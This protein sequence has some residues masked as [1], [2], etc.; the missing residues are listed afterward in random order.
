LLQ[1]S[2]NPVDWYPWGTDALDKARAENKPIFLSIGYSACHW[3]HVME[4]ESFENDDIAAI[5]NRHFVNIKVD[6]EERPDLDDFFMTFLQLTTGAGGWPM[7]VFLTPDGKPFFGGTYFPPEDAYGRRGFPF[8]LK[9]VTQTWSVQQQQVLDSST[10]LLAELQANLAA[11]GPGGT[12]KPEILE[13]AMRQM[14]DRFDPVDGGFGG[15]PKFPPSYSL[16]LLMK[17]YSRSRNPHLLRAIFHTLDRMAFGGIYDHL[18]GGFHRY[19]VDAQWLTPH[20]EKMLY[21]NAL[22]AAVYLEAYQLTGKSLYRT[23]ATETLDYVLR[24]MRDPA[25]GF[26]SSEDADSE[27][28]EGK[29]YVW[30]PEEVIAALGSHN[31]KLFCD[32]YDVTNAGNF[33]ENHSILNLR[34]DPTKFAQSYALTPDQLE[35][36]LTGLRAEML[37]LRSKRIRPH[38]DDKILTEWNGLMLSALAKGY[39]ITND[40]RYLNAARDCAQFLESTMHR[41]D[42]LLRVYR[43]GHAKQPGFLADYAFTA[44]GLVDLYE[45]SFDIHWL[46]LAN[47]LVE[48]MVAKFLD[49]NAGGFFMTLADQPDLPVRPKDSYDGAVP[50]G[51]SVAAMAL[52]RLSVLLGR[53]DFLDLALGTMLSLAGNVNKIPIA[54]MNLLNAFDF[55]YYPPSEIAIVGNRND[56]ATAAL[57]E[58][59]YTTYVPNK[60]IAFLDPN[61]PNS[62]KSREL[63]PLLQDR[64][65][66]DNTATAY[67]CKD[68]VCKL[69][70]VKAEELS[71]QLADSHS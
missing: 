57:I 20:F 55:R 59:A 3:C 56:P 6:R 32:Y 47:R 60:V 66:I 52:L 65:F 16:S 69:P 15:P 68:F 23:V 46:K 7:S 41:D 14:L 9:A 70:V 58:A 19:S 43:Q 10:S 38:K 8:I 33:D 61:E 12:L 39:Q 24:D 51:N 21:D 63:I 37:D 22:L 67:V 5:M 42:G 1:H 30:T 25:G 49:V 34:V 62:A 2:T 17:Q 29:F 4:R 11:T 31:G 71:K 54:F 36:K 44:N 27:G 35:S 50:S 45:T 53:N 28:I 13:E 40:L 48:E 64:S 26:F 18:G